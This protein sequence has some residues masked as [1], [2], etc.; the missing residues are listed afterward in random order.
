MS[1]CSVTKTILVSSTWSLSAEAPRLRCLHHTFQIQTEGI[2]RHQSYR[3]VSGWLLW[4]LFCKTN[5]MRGFRLCWQ[6]FFIIVWMK[7]YRSTRCMRM[8]SDLSSDT[9]AMPNA[10]RAE[11][12]RRPAFSQTDARIH[13]PSSSIYL[14][15]TFSLAFASLNT[16]KKV[17]LIYLSYFQ[18]IWLYT[19]I[20]TPERMVE[21]NS[22][23]VSVTQSLFEIRAYFGQ[24]PV[25][26][27]EIKL[28]QFVRSAPSL[29]PPHTQSLNSSYIDNIPA[30]LALPHTFLFKFIQRVLVQCYKTP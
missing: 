20:S 23:T 13:P 21:I 9:L 11:P 17:D 30:S 29:L 16:N 26:L 1:V 2:F 10:C 6:N 25:R 15:P 24:C 14:P 22:S 7:Q 27:S 28:V 8:D 4:K 19:F 5:T 3:E 12:G 18:F